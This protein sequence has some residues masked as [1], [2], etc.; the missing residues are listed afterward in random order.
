[1]ASFD[2]YTNHRDNAGVSGVVF[3][4]EKPLLEVEMNEVQEIQKSMLRRAIKNIIGDGVT[5]LSKIVYEGG[6]V[7]VKEGCALAVDGYMVEST[8]L[9]ITA[10]SG[11]VYLQVWEETAT[12]S[13]TLKKEGNQQ[14]S[15]TVTNWFKD[16]RSDTE[17]S[18]RKVVKYTLA[19]TTDSARH[20]LAIAKVADG[21]MTR[22]CKEISFNNLSNTVIDLQVQLGTLGEGVMGVEVDLD[23]NS[24]KR[25]GDNQYW[26][27]GEDYDKS[28]VYGNRRRCNV[29]D[30]GKV[31]AFYGDTAYTET[32]ALTVAVG[33]VAVGTK[34]QCMVMQPKFYYKRIPVRLE[35]QVDDTYQVKGYHMTKWIDLI[36]PTARDGFK[37]HPAFKKG[38]VE[39]DYYFIG[40]NDGC[41]ESADGAYDMND[42]TVTIGSSPYTGIKFSSIAG[43]KP[44][45][46]SSKADISKN[47]ALTRDAI[48]KM[49]ANRG[50][51]WIQ[52]DITIASA[53]QML[54]VV[55]YA[56][57]NIQAVSVFGRGVTNLPW[58]DNINNSVPNPAN[59]TL[60]NGSGKITVEYT[61]SNG[62]T[63]NVDVSVYRGVKNPFGNIWKFIDGF[64]RKH[65]AS[66]DC[67][68]AYW[69]DG[70][71]DFSDAIAD[72][73]ATGFSCA[74]KEG[75]IKAFGYSEDCDFMYMTSKVGGDS[76]R[77]VGDYYYVNMSNNN[78]YIARLGA[79]WN[80][81]AVSG[82]FC[83]SLGIVASDRSCAIGG[84]LCRKSKTVTIAVA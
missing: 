26:S 13:E 76:N 15:A 32:G 81:G 25:M 6:A 41:L 80:G 82:L 47:N 30:D 37:L 21:V 62:T 63:Y 72:Y 11:T 83:W 29:T 48:R 31:V 22:L 27:A 8:G 4:A 10:S 52:E 60:G 24:V 2:K 79:Y 65:S 56:T 78:I 1:M 39:L 40:E 59:T 49:C 66:S 20:N 14:D 9:S 46:G 5:D 34:V 74:T 58:V 28:P 33:D 23:N 75:Y 16:N 61:H 68:E 3:G 51:D 71:K 50:V 64:L 73:I 55:E 42:N 7:K 70:S 43:A 17:T 45:S 67:N 44:A 77:P 36:S 53:E 54:F 18:R 69:Q 57:F 35:K 38:D 84:R 19:T 12:Y